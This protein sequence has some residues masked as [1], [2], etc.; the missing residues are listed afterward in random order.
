MVM[1]HPNFQKHLSVWKFSLVGG[2]QHFYT[3]FIFN[4]FL[5]S[6]DFHIFQRG[7]YTT[8]Q[9]W[10]FPLSSPTSTTTAIT[11]DLHRNQLADSRALPLGT[12]VSPTWSISVP[13]M[14]ATLGIVEAR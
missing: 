5:F 11:A 7:R 4:H 6:T 13:H 9:S 14:A 1:G 3:F 12:H 10:F 8:N 2:F